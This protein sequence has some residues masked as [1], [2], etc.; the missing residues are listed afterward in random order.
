MIYYTMFWNVGRHSVILL[1]ANEFLI[2]KQNDGENNVER[3]R[4]EIRRI[5]PIY[6]GIVKM[7][8]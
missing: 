2:P 6:L 3:S 4:I 1:I 7:G 8:M 5:V